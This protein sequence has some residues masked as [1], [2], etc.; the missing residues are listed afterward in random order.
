MSHIQTQSGDSGRDADQVAKRST[1][2]IAAT[3]WWLFRRRLTHRTGRMIHRATRWSRLPAT[4]ATTLFLMLYGMNGAAML[5]MRQP[6]APEETIGW[7]CGGMMLYLLYHTV[8]CVYGRVDDLEISPAAELWIGGA[9]VSMLTKL[10]MVG[11]DRILATVVKAGLLLAALWVDA[12]NALFMFTGLAMALLMVDLMRDVIVAAMAV[13]TDRNRKWAKSAVTIIAAAVIVLALSRFATRDA[14]MQSPLAMIMAAFASVGDV[15]SNDFVIL[16]G[17]WL[18]PAATLAVSNFDWVAVMVTLP[19]MI[20]LAAGLMYARVQLEVRRCQLGSGGVGESHETAGGRHLFR[21]TDDRRWTAADLLVYRSLAS[22]WRY[23]GTIALS[24]VLPTFL[25]LSPIF[26]GD[27]PDRWMFV[28]GG[29]AFCTAML[30]PS[31]L[32]IDFR[33]DLRRIALLRSLPVSP[34][35]M[36][37]G[38]IAVPVAITWMFQAL[39]IGVATIC[40]NPGVGPTLMWTGMLMSLA[41]VTFCSEN[42]LFLAFPYHAHDNGLAMVVRAKLTFLAKSTVLVFALLSLAATAVACRRWFGDYASL[43]IVMI[44]VVFSMSI[45]AL[46]FGLLAR[47]WRRFDLARDLPLS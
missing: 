4:A 23:R 47:S 19:I 14:A 42:A 5:S 30:A 6:S 15:A 33:S 24:F 31:A 40:L 39:V 44:P 45:A 36:S 2:S 41:V 32:K 12:A 28:V 1:P 17:I 9:P 46:A 27:L 18:R 38:K 10:V 7:L 35:V 26:A 8:R 43:A 20:S 13:G 3:T 16:S 21:P 37:F 22:A 34:S 11:S 25:C 29:V